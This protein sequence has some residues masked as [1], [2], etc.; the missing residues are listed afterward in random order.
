MQLGSKSLVEERFEVPLGG[1]H[2][3]LPLVARST[4]RSVARLG[5]AAR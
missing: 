1:R 4:N 2:L 3:P 5:E